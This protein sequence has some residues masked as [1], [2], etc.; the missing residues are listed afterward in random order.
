MR[1]LLQSVHARTKELE[2]NSRVQMDV[3]LCIIFMV[4]GLT[5]VPKIDREPVS[6]QFQG[7]AFPSP[8]LYAAYTPLAERRKYAY[9]LR[10]TRIGT[11][12]GD[13]ITQPVRSSSRETLTLGIHRL[14]KIG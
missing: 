4:V 13:E 6:R 12:V 7:L 10:T 8:A 1:L 5:A 2:V 11:K 9:F 14:T 3:K